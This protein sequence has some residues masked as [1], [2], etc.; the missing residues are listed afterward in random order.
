MKPCKKL[1]NVV[2]YLIVTHS[3]WVGYG[4]GHIRYTA[5]TVFQIWLNTSPPLATQLH[6]YMEKTFQILKALSSKRKSK[7]KIIYIKYIDM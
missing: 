3:H 2:K 7:L 6:R 4:Y 5:C 1:N